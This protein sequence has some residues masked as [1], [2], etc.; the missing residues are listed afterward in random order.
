MCWTTSV[1][2]IVDL[3]RDVDEQ[4]DEKAMLLQEAAPPEPILVRDQRG[5]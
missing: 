4:A 3:A 2:Q 5:P 1:P